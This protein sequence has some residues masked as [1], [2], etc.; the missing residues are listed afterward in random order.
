MK[1][2]FIIS[3][4]CC[5]VLV[6]GPACSREVSGPDAQPKTD[7]HVDPGGAYT[8]TTLAGDS[9]EVAR[10]ADG[11]GSAA[12]FYAP[13]GVAID[14][15]GTLYVADS[16]NHTIRKIT[17]GAVVTTVAGLPGSEGKTDGTGTAAGFRDPYGIAVDKNGIIYVADTS[18]NLIRK[19]TPDGVVTTLA[20]G[21]AQGSGDGTGANVGFKEPRGIGVD[22]AGNVFVADYGNAT[23]R[24]ITPAGVVSTFAGSAGNVGS[25]DGKGTAARFR[26]LYS[27]V[28]GPSDIVY[29]SDTGNRAIRKIT[30]DGTVSTLVGGP[31]LQWRELRGLST[32]SSGNVYVADFFG[33][34]IFKVTSDGNA[35]LFAGALNTPGTSDASGMAAGFFNP[36][37]V[38]V[39]TD[40]TL[41][42]ADTS[43]NTIR[44]VTS[45]GEV[46]T[47]AGLAGRSASVD[48]IGT[49][50]RFE[51]PYASAVDKDG[52]V[53]IADSSDHTIRRISSAGEVT[54]FAGKAGSYG[55][56]DG[57]G[58]AARFL[59]PL[60]IAIGAD[61]SVYVADTG[62]LTIRK[63]SADRT[64][65]TLAGQAGKA[66]ST[67]GSGLSG[68]FSSPAGIAVS[69]DGTLYVA[70]SMGATIRQITSAGEVTTLAGASGQN[71]FVDGPVA[72]ARFSVPFDV[73]VDAGG[74]VYVSDH[75]NHA[76]RRIENGTVTTLAGTGSAGN[77]DGTG[78]NASFRWPSGI[79]VSANGTVFVADTDN[80]VIRR[81]L[82]SGEV[83]VVGGMFRKTGSS[84]GVGTDALFFNPKDV[85]VGS[86]GS[87]VVV[88]RGNY[89]IRVGRQ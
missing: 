37:G 13:R 32:D 52:N 68:R 2:Q 46:S 79:G 50:A 21:G 40:G 87:L 80:H 51:N 42:V 45:S 70:E 7:A 85:A 14:S 9:S 61:G 34:G 66:G 39:A 48:G 10:S 84:D 17:P 19:V 67:D 15:S 12:Q 6:L 24:K 43:N 56:D 44:K 55:A 86:D 53:F 62:N 64:V 35:S 89:L 57:A 8:F 63:I 16:S 20:G 81:I 69:G 88:D 31:G 71:G 75:G 47:F 28:V 54:T 36:S 72:D 58:D 82:P 78:V 29:V 26:G 49:A 30:P 1:N 38:T 83:S 77:E 73:A 3:L 59:A 41:Y 18:N 25:E 22:S 11:V 5:A 65:T 74:V 76:I 60:G 4:F 23:V 33:H 27:L